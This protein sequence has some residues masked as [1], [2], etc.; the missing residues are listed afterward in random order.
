MAQG[1]G[2]CQPPCIDPI[3]QGQV[4]LQRIGHAVCARRFQGEQPGGALVLRTPQ[5]PVPDG[6]PFQQAYDTAQCGK[7]FRLDR[8]QFWTAVHPV[9]EWQDQQRFGQGHVI[10]QP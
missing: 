6:D 2:E 3:E 8:H 1:R 9:Q 10:A 5:F 7:P 4:L